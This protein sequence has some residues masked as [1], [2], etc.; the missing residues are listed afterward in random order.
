MAASAL[1]L[2]EY[3]AAGDDRLLGALLSVERQGELGPLADRL[4][5]DPRPFARRVLEGY[6]ADG[7]DRPGHRLFVKTVFK[8]AEKV[9]DWRLMAHLLVAFDRLVQRRRVES[10]SYDWGTRTSSRRMVLREPGWMLRRLPRLPEGARREYR[11][12]VTGAR[13]LVRR[14]HVPVRRSWR[15][16]LSEGVDP[17]RFS[18]STRRYLQRRC[19]RFF[20]QLARAAP[21][22]F[23]DAATLALSLYRDEHLSTSEALIDAWG[24]V[25]LL[26]HGSPV[27]ERFPLGARVRPGRS[28]AELDWAPFAEALWRG[29]ARPLLALVTQ[30]RAR[31]V[32]RFALWA[33]ARWHAP[34]LDGLPV[35][36]LLAWL[37]APH[38]EQQRAGLEALARR[39]DLGSLP[40]GQWL[41]LLQLEDPEIVLRVCALV[42]QHVAPSRLSLAQCVTLACAS[43]V[44]VAKLGLAWARAW[45]VRSVEELRALVELRA[46]PVGP[47]RE[48]AMQWVAGLLSVGDDLRP[49]LVRELID[50]RYVDVRAVG[51]GLMSRHVRFGESL[52]LWLA[53]A[54]TP[55]PDVREALVT[56]LQQQ[57]FDGAT[58]H[59]VWATTILDVQRGS[60]ARP[61]AL[62]QAAQ[63]AVAQPQEAS[64]LLQLLAHALRSVRPA[65]RRSALA[66]IVQGAT[67]DPAFAAL[68]RERLP[69]LDL[70]R[71]EVSA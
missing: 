19:W 16:E 23:V 60:R 44:P 25:H 34:A 13:T 4:L 26:W 61:R 33:L 32:R 50:A 11:N 1:L 35:A 58:L 62:A 38:E 8:H 64:S 6:L 30:A 21:D 45:P 29:T 17:L 51:L 3:F 24:L 41:S 2:E 48:E 59:R 28:L 18:L 66:V 67:R 42:E 43:A 63:R 71:D 22:A 31:P 65:E 37:Q 9:S 5:R 47:V 56:R 14:P 49:E 70:G 69:E 68:V 53:M 46:A 55:H 52:E 10:W 27:I 15:G 36:T 12:P 57:R 20:R 39:S 7:C 40:L 54:E